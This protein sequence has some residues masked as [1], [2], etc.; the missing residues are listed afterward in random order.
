MQIEIPRTEH[1]LTKI[2]STAGE[3]FHKNYLGPIHR[4]YNVP[5]PEGID[6]GDLEVVAE[7][8]DN[9]G[10]S[11]GPAV[12]LKSRT[13]VKVTVPKPTIEPAPKKVEP[14]PERKPRAKRKLRDQEIAQDER[15]TE[16]PSAAD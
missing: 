12:I 2:T 13:K 9:D 10:K 3:W 8:C 6:V 14:K 5:L 1:P 11:L 4:T 15:P 16:Q 7:P